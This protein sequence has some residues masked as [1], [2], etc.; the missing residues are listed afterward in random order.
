[1]NAEMEILQALDAAQAVF[2]QAS[3]LTATDRGRLAQEALRQVAGAPWSMTMRA[4]EADQHGWLEQLRDCLRRMADDPDGVDVEE[5]AE[6][7]LW[8]ANELERD[9]RTLLGAR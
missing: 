1:M 6:E 2:K 9:L 7:G 5:A 8:A 3:E 4:A